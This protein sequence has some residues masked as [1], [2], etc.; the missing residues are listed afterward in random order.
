MK[1]ELE[2]LLNSN[3]GTLQINELFRLRRI[4]HDADNDPTGLG[5]TV[6]SLKLEMTAKD[7]KNVPYPVEITFRTFEDIKDEVA[8][9]MRHMLG[10]Y[11]ENV[12]ARWNGGEL[13]ERK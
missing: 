12:V 11:T 3:N 5:R 7:A 4:S 8:V 2:A 10:C 6:D 13:K 9:G 1:K